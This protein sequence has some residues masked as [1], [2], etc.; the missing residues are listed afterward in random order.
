MIHHEYTIILGHSHLSGSIG[1]YR[2]NISSHIK[3]LECTASMCND[4]RRLQSI[5]H[6]STCMSTTKIMFD[7]DRP[8]LTRVVHKTLFDTS[9]YG[10]FDLDCLV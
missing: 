5:G 7:D 6:D 2:R 4:A 10:Q 1:V 9:G 3:G 8:R